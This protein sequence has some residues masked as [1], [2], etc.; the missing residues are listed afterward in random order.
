MTKATKTVV[1][2]EQHNGSAN[3]P[4]EVVPEGGVPP[5]PPEDAVE[6]PVAAPVW[7]GGSPDLVEELPPPEADAK[8]DDKGRKTRIVEDEE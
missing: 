6:V 3:P 8:D 2:V 5:Y 7:E 4:T 1:E